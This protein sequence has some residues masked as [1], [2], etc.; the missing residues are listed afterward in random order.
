MRFQNGSHEGNET[1]TI[2]L[3]ETY[4]FKLIGD[5]ATSINSFQIVIDSFYAFVTIE[6]VKLSKSSFSINLQLSTID[7][8]NSYFIDSTIAFNSKVNILNST[9]Q[10]TDFT[11]RKG[12]LNISGNVAFITYTSSLSLLNSTTINIDDNA[13]VKFCRDFTCNETG[14][15][16]WDDPDMWLNISSGNFSEI[17]LSDNC[18]F[19]YC[20]KFCNEYDTECTNVKT[21]NS[22]C[23]S[24]RAETLCGRC[25][26]SSSLGIGYDFS[27]HICTDNDNLALLILFAAA[28]PLL[29]VFI[30]ILNLTVTQGVINGLIFYANVIWAYKDFFFQIDRFAEY[31]YSETRLDSVYFYLIYNPVYV[32][33]AW[34]NL[35]FGIPSCFFKNLTAPVKTSLEFIF[36]FYIAILF[37]IGLRYSSK[38]SKIL[39]SRSVP[40]LATLLFLSYTKLLRTIITCLQVATYNVHS[41]HGKKV[42]HHVWALDGQPYASD[43]MRGHVFLFVF[44]LVCLILFWMPY[45][46]LLFFMQW[47]S[48]LLYTSPSPRDAT[49]SRMPSS[50]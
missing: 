16:V 46:F 29:I 1:K 38:L 31:S 37:F 43:F 12:E 14:N 30:S 23:A 35:D 15:I 48:C 22:Q 10:S 18:P 26:N 9:F 45:T 32:I 47:L 13:S 40:T 20:R 11:L 34:L 36:P 41:P 27:C 3:K 6:R 2:V 39:G 8:T 19:G 50:A 21:L 33:L 49:L 4:H 5:S 25:D 28:G 24:F 17:K 42:V 44:A 7:V